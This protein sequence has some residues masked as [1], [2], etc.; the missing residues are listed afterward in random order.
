[1]MKWMKLAVRNILR[2]KRRSLV[3]LL[4]IGV[5]FA[6]ISLFRG[7]VSNVYSGLRISAIRGEGLGHLTIYK[8]GWLEKGKLDPERYMF[9]KEENEKAIHLIQGEKEVVLATPQIQVTGIVSNGITSTIFIAQGVVPKDDKTIKGAWAAFRPIKGASLDDKKTYGVEMAQDLAAFL[10]LASGKDGVV[11]ATT[12]G[13]QMNAMDIQVNGVYDSGS[14]ATN[15]KFMRFT[16]DFARSLVDTQSTERIVV[17]LH[18]WEMTEM[19]R[20]KLL[21]KLNQAGL[22]CEI[23][24]WN[25]LSLFY[26][27]VRVMFDVIFMF[28]FSIVL[29]IVVMSTVNTMG[30]A[31]LERTREIGTLRALGLKRRGV[32]LLFAL[33]GGVLGFFGSVIGIILHIIGWTLIRAYPPTYTPP[34]IS[35]PVPLIVDLVPEVLTVLMLCLI[36]LSLLAAIIP[37][38]RAAGQ[39]VVEAL[40]HV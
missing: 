38:R 14:D 28:I 15:D 34:G 36:L 4:A 35:T 18:D 30:M 12:L 7:Y 20:S 21:I 5:G 9:T 40:G 19:M 1:M 24:T 6:A 16:Y 3:T 22:N 11:M 27:K 31:V 39:N 25:E 32:S 29:V 8:A 33:E 2:N 13:G 23:K 17:L 26:S 37:A 10:N